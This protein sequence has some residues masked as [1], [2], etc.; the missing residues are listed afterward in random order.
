M[1]VTVD[2]QK[3]V[4]NAFA[5]V[6]QNNLT[7]ADAVT[8]NQQSEMMNDRNGLL[9]SEQVGPRFAVTR[10]TSG[11]QDLTTGTQDSVFGSE[12]FIIKD[13]FGTSMG[14]ADFVRI[15]DITEARESISLRNAATQLAEIIDAYVLGFATNASNNYVGTVGNNVASWSDIQTAYTR[16]KDEGCSDDDLRAILTYYDK[17]A[18]GANVLSL[19][20]LDNI[21]DGIY[22]KAFTGE[23]GG[24]PTM[25][26]Q[27]L[28]TFTAGTRVATGS[29]TVNAANQ[30]VNYKAV[31]VSGAPGQY[32][33]QT[34]T[35]AATTGQTFNDGDIFTIANV[36]AWDNRA[37]RS[38]ARLQQFRVVGNATAAGSTV[39]LRIFPACIVPATGTGGD[40]LVNTAHATVDS[41]PANGAAVTFLGT[42]GQAYQPRVLLQKQAIVVD[43]AQLI[44]PATGKSMTKSLTKVPVS[45]R[46]WQHS[47][48]NTGNHVVRFDVALTAN[49][50]D[51]R[52]IV[53]LNGA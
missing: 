31:A 1:A 47:D 45:V 40:I 19:P 44:T 26:T 43:T 16:L 28:P 25:F 24:I 11:V 48:F 21:A 20:S 32:L 53:R 18:L 36:N 51:R 35:F 2:Q 52:R 29:V 12:Q 13:V 37:Q 30:N 41:I 4:L 39:T 7:V 46:M 15:R 49:V 5:A 23:V 42:A 8:W 17:Q 9:V 27:Q 34:M 38:L 6:F 3:L 10:T 14:W 22:R 33:T 50:R